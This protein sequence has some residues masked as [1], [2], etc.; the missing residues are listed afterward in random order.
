MISSLGVESKSI[1]ENAIQPVVK[2]FL[3]ER[4]LELSPEK[5]LITHIEATGNQ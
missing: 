2:G 5:T 3:A 4:G 1:L